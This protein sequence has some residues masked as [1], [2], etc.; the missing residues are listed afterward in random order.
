MTDT[1]TLVAG[2]YRLCAP[3]GRGAMGEVWQAFDEHLGREVAVK[4]LLESAPGENAAARL[5]VEARAAARLNHPHVGAV[6]DAG[7]FEGRGYLV[8][9]LVPGRTLAAELAATGPMSPEDAARTAAQAAEGLAAAHDHGIVHRDIKPSN[10]L[11]HD[12]TLKIADFGIARFT[13]ETAAGTATGTGRILGT[14]GY[15]APERAKGGPA[16]FAS[17]VYALGCVLYEL[18][19]G[20]P[21]FEA[22]NPAAVL[23]QH[24]DSAPEPLARTRSDVPRAMEAFLLRMLAKDPAARPT[25]AEAA[26]FFGSDAWRRA[27]AAALLPGG[28]VPAAAG[29]TA[30]GTVTWRGMRAARRRR[31]AGALS[32][33]AGAAALTT[34]AL[35]ALSPGTA[36]SGTDRTPDPALT[37]PA[38]APDATGA[39]SAEP[40][41]VPESGVTTAT[42]S[43][44]VS[45]TVTV[46][47]EARDD[48]P[49]WSGGRGREGRDRSGDAAGREQGPGP[50]R[51]RGED[52]GKN[53]ESGSG[54]SGRQEQDEEQGQ[55]KGQEQEQ[56]G[57]QTPDR[58]PEPDVS[59]EPTP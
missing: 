35:V 28:A 16:G 3:L 58:S 42:V 52:T 2:R 50:D 1:R 59:P 22:D 49:P 6:Y 13:D 4:M 43:A 46:T 32:G 57:G 18:L 40:S 27:T 54:D 7:V 5:D 47:A 33:I 9:E 45:A 14:V 30:N 36:G 31:S 10:L 11:V 20:R 55:D 25:A 8:M 41:S 44:T 53:Q 12:R 29:A 48:G 26:E 38:S 21:P 15:L 24:V 39:P 34:A 56:D 19:S 17:D 51:H 23:F 37:R